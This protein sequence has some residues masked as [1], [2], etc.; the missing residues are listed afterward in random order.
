M[1]FLIIGINES[2]RKLIAKKTYGAIE[3]SHPNELD[4]FLTKDSLENYAIVYIANDESSKNKEY[5]SF[6]KKLDDINEFPLCVTSITTLPLDTEL[7]KQ[8]VALNER[9]ILHNA[10][11]KML[12]ECA[13]YGIIKIEKY[14]DKEEIVV[15][16]ELK[17]GRTE[18]VRYLLDRFTD[19][20]LSPKQNRDF[21]LLTQQLLYARENKLIAPDI[22]KT[23]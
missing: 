1:K 19:T 2:Q 9:Y 13:E 14:E 22:K 11:I 21:A 10:T 20:L 8:A 23:N 18:E 15:S 17:N 6:E 16:H 5:M 12:R 3:V 4:T 7:E